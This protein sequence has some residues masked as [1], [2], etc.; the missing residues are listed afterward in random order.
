MMILSKRGVHNINF[1][2]GTQYAPAIVEAVALARSQGLKLPIVWNSSGYETKETIDL[3]NGTIDIYLTDIKYADNGNAVLF[4]NAPD[5][6]EISTRAAIRMLEQVGP[7]ETDADGLGVRGVIVRHLVLPWG[8]AGTARVMAFIADVLGPNVPI[9][10]MGQ[11]F[12]AHRAFEREET[13]QQLST[14]EYDKAKTIVRSAG[15]TRGWF[16]ER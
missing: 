5:Y 9:S 7:L 10:L 8:L 12:P 1:V 15:I 13:S 3:L 16:Q 2:T 6:F 14:E 4:S 11:Y